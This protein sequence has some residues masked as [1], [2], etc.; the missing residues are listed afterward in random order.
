L[1]RLGEKGGLPV[2]LARLDRLSL[3]APSTIKIDAED[4]EL[5]VLEGAVEV[6][7]GARPFIVFENWLH[8]DNPDLTLAPLS[9][10]SARRYR[11]FAPGWVC[12]DPDCILSDPGASSELALVPFLQAQ[13]FQLPTQ[14]NIIAVPV[15][16][17][18]EF[19]ERLA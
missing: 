19:R 16:R 9:L 8:L 6:I 5:E 3:P 4:H 18:D 13:R 1:A 15:E 17:M 7:D 14:M 12:G 2:R 10:L 11:F